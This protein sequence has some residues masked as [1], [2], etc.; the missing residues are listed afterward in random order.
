M[1]NL[2]SNFPNAPA[3]R[4]FRARRPGDRVLCD[5]CLAHQTQFRTANGIF[6]WHFIC[7]RYNTS[8]RSISERRH[9]IPEVYFINAFSVNLCYSRELYRPFRNY[10]VVTLKKNAKSRW[11]KP[12][13]STGKWIKYHQR[14]V[15]SSKSTSLYKGAITLQLYCRQLKQSQNEVRAAILK[16]AALYRHLYPTIFFQNVA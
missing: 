8:K 1:D 6:A 4:S 13:R 11:F 14:K 9:W 2:I 7:F 15:S 3:V 5:I 10:L 12:E 16:M